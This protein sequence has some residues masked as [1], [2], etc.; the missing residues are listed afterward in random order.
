MFVRLTVLETPHVEPRRGVA[1]CGIVGVRQLPVPRLEQVP[2]DVVGGLLVPI[3][4]RVAAVEQGLRVGR[5]GD[6]FLCVQRK[7]AGH[8]SG[9]K[10]EWETTKHVFLFQGAPSKKSTTP[11]RKQYSAPTISSLSCSTS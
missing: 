2:Y 8:E 9:G 10:W 4:L 1:L 11:V 6:G 3:E 5:A 7:A